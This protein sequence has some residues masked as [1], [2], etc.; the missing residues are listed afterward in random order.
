MGCSCG[1]SCAVCLG[2]QA[3]DETVSVV[4]GQEKK[5]LYACPKI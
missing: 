5:N 3:A 2:I 1:V 4:V